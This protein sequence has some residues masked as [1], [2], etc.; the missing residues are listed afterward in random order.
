MFVLQNQQA[1][2]IRFTFQQALVSLLNTIQIKDPKANSRNTFCPAIIDTFESIRKHESPENSICQKIPTEQ[3]WGVKLD[4]IYKPMLRVFRSICIERF[5]LWQ[6]EK[7][8]KYHSLAS[9]FKMESVKKFMENELR[10]PAV[11]LDQ[12]NVVKMCILLI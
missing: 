5:N 11:L 8:K 9:H 12:E 7:K 3:T 10:L 1:R 2:P 4:Q 6:G